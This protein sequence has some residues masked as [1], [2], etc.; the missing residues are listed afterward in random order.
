VTTTST[1][2]ARGDQPQSTSSA[3]S[4]VLG[5]VV[6]AGLGLLVVLGLIISPADRIQ[7]DAVRI[8]YVHVP[9]AIT[10]YL[11][12]AVTAVGSIAYLWKRSRW[13]DLMAAAAAEIGVVFT[14][15]TLITGMIWGNLTWG[16][17]WVW[18]ARLTSTALLFVLFIGYLA[19]RSIPADRATRAKRSAVVGI[20]AFLDVPIVHFSVD[21]WRGQHQPATLSRLDPTIDGLMLFTMVFGMAVFALGFGWLLLHGF[22]VKWLTEQDESVGLEEAILERRSAAGSPHDQSQPADAI[23]DR[24]AP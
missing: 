3:A 2:S 16:A 24:S 13:W 21:W 14:A 17:Y 7:G 6:L 5:A 18:D 22:R 1:N 11:A 19:V 20:I 9:S 10:A 8:M 12:F 23:I 4:R 15:T